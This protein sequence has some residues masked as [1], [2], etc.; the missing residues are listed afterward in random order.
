MSFADGELTHGG[1]MFE[2]R[3]FDSF[4]RCEADSTI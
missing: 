2:R 1:L 3:L 4:W